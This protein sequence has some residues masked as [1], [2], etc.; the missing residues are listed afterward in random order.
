MRKQIVGIFAQLAGGKDTVANYLVK[1]LNGDHEYIPYSSNPEY[2]KLINDKHMELLRDRTVEV[3]LP[4]KRLGFA[5]AVK[6]VFMDAFNVT[7]DFI[8]EWKRKDE[9]PPGF[10]LNIRKG[11]QHIGDGFR[12]IQSDVW[13]STAMRKGDRSV[14][15][16]GRYLNEAKMI[17]EEGGVTVLLWRPGFENDDP[18]PS[19]AQIKPFVDFCAKNRDE[20]PL[21]MWDDTSLQQMAGPPSMNNLHYFDYFLINDGTLENLYNKIDSKLIPYLTKAGIK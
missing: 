11:L 9:V 18:N 21:K 4:W 15:S 13:I 14:I 1:K 3:R 12:K 16:D 6:H 19:E 10:D 5:D 7:W 17:Q 20:G 2:E 8:E